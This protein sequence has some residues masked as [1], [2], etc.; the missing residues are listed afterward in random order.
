MD[1]DDATGLQQLQQ[2]E[3]R[4]HDS[5]QGQEEGIVAVLDLHM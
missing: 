1:P 5:N 2:N 4:R 3:E